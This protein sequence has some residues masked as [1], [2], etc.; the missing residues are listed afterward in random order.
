MDR[1]DSD[2]LCNACPQ[3]SPRVTV[4]SVHGGSS[5]PPYR[6]SCLLSRYPLYSHGCV[7]EHHCWRSSQ[8]HPSR[9]GQP[10]RLRLWR[11]EVSGVPCLLSD[12]ELLCRHSHQ[13]T[14][15]IGD[16]GSWLIDTLADAGYSGGSHQGI[17]YSNSTDVY[18]G[19]LQ[20]GRRVG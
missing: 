17:N 18:F 14:D 3:L 4:G 20:W 6:R 16:G 9:C 8:I 15:T 19:G 7:S 10:P 12:S 5:Q 1:T 2:H 13:S 11:Y